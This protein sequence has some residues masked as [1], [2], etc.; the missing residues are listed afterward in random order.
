MEIVEHAELASRN[1]LA[2]NASA[3]YLIEVATLEAL[4]GALRFASKQELPVIPLGGGS[5]VVLAGALKAVVIQLKL[6]G[7][8]VLSSNKDA[9]L[10]QA[11]AGE[12]WHSF[13]RWTLVAGAYGLENL[14][15]IPGC[16]GAAPV[17]NIGAY[18]VELK[19][20]FH[21]LTAVDIGSGEVVQMSGNDCQFAYRDSVFKQ[22][23]KD[24]Y[25]I[26]SV[27]FKLD[28]VLNP[29]LDYGGLKERVELLAAER[30][31]S[32]GLISDVVSE[33]RREK[34]PDPNKLANAGSFF[35]NPRV[36]NA[37]FCQL[38]D[39]YPEIVAYPAGQENWKLAAGWLIE[40]AGLK[41]IREG[42]VGTHKKQALVLVNHGGATGEDVIAFSGLIQ[43]RVNSLF[44]VMLEREPRVYK[45]QSVSC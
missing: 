10:V 15:L 6:M 14:S 39:Q 28:K 42:A 11:G 17:Q 19:D 35:K 31:L 34:L 37:Q 45:G 18:G 33:I 25:I 21:A 26:T 2:L 44:G 4:Q 32:A 9:V 3:R 1:T 24:R 12:D 23:W 41:G 8:T 5:N 36:N 30:E 13:V 40:K 22:I 7:K 16:V 43:R 20:Y 38:K 29:H 27:Q